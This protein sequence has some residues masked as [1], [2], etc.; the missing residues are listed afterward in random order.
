M[1]LHVFRCRTKF[2]SMAYCLFFPSKINFVAHTK[3]SH[4]VLAISKA[5]LQA[6]WSLRQQSG[7]VT[8]LFTHPYTIDQNFH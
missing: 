4:I 6:V 2:I 8:S 5:Y 7:F 3:A 1:P